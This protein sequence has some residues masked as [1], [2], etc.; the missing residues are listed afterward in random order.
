[1]TIDNS[2]H[3]LL[4]LLDIEKTMSIEHDL[5][6]LL[7]MLS[8][9]TKELLNVERCSVFVHEESENALVTKFAD[10]IHKI[11][12]PIDKGVVGFTFESGVA[13]V[14]NDVSKS[15]YFYGGVDDESGFVTK[16]L[17]TQP[18]YDSHGEIIGVFEA[19]NKIEGEFSDVDFSLLRLISQHISNGIERAKKFHN[20]NATLRKEINI[21]LMG[22]NVELKERIKSDL[23]E[24]IHAEIE[25]FELTQE[26]K[27]AIE[28]NRSKLYM[29]IL[30]VEQKEDLDEIDTFSTN[31]NIPIIVIGADDYD[32]SLYAG[33]FNIYS[34]LSISNYSASILKEKI[35]SSSNYIASS[36][37]KQ[38][39]VYAFTGI[40][41]GI[42]TTTV[43]MNLATLVAENRP[44]SNVLYLD[45]SPTKAISNLFFGIPKP[46]KDISDI[47]AS[48][49]ESHKELLEHGLHQI[50][51]NFYFIPG[52]QSHAQRD[53]LFS[54]ESE[55]AMSELIYNL[56]KDFDYIFID[57]GIAEDS[58]LKIL[59]EEMSDDIFVL[60]ELT[61][62]HISILKV[63][64]ELI[65]QV[66]WK[67][68]IHLVINR[69]NAESAIS[70]SDAS[71]IINADK[72][73]SQVTFDNTLPN[74]SK[75]LRETWNYAELICHKYPNSDFVQA[76]QKE[77][78]PKVLFENEGNAQIETKKEQ[79]IGF[80]K[81]LFS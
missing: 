62:A 31:I 3:K 7:E 36:K 81:R 78:L 30:T 9:I 71:D 74:D 11:K 40:S 80:F 66:G 4:L 53:S 41:G 45:I 38:S 29:L 79:K 12:L 57:V 2:E 51:N 58:E 65:K 16:Q 64:Y 18:I 19:I 34:Y 69:S 46:I 48:E 25:E 20:S 60:T 75:L 54:P 63:Y 21:A 32:L 27:K 73:S 6:Q 24:N 55:R 35:H 37:N 17:F 44:Y 13:Q 70:V 43:A 1:M 26:L 8:D 56:K 77:L 47:L 22:K 14:I 52:I 67:E 42:G 68:K 39:K 50:S 28:D 49:Y 76:L 10:G 59:L 5:Y 61:T 33:Q 23:K 15:K 72:S